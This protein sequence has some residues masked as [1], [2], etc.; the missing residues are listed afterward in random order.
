M[1]ALLV[2]SPG[3]LAATDLQEALF[4]LV[5]PDPELSGDR[6]V[7]AVL[8]PVD[9]GTIA[10]GEYSA[11]NA[12]DFAS[13]RIR[14]RIRSGSFYFPPYRLWARVL[15]P[16]DPTPGNFNTFDIGM[17][18]QRIRAGAHVVNPNYDY[19]PETASK[20]IDEVPIFPGTVGALGFS[21]PYT[22]LYRTTGFHVG[23]SNRF[24]LVFAVGPQ[25]YSFDSLE[26][27]VIEIGVTL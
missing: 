7:S 14:I 18:I 27:V 13:G 4:E 3:R 6:T 9:L 22:E 20:D 11:L 2:V 17:G 5:L 26:G 16:H 25:F 1:T 8:P 12:A 21:P 23:R 10:M 19:D 15:T 24:D